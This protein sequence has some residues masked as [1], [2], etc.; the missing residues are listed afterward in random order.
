[1]NETLGIIHDRKSIRQFLG[2][3]IPDKVKAHIIAATLR[4]RQ[5]HP[6]VVEKRVTRLSAPSPSLDLSIP[7]FYN[8]YINQ[9][10]RQT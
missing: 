7:P 2:K 8:L 3:P 1:M 6:Q 9:S 5:S 10:R 4:S